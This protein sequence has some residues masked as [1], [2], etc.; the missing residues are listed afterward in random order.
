[1]NTRQMKDTLQ[2]QFEQHLPYQD[3]CISEEVQ[4]LIDGMFTYSVIGFESF[5][6]TELS[7]AISSGIYPQQLEEQVNTYTEQVNKLWEEW[8]E[9]EDIL[10]LVNGL[11]ED[12]YID[13]T[14][15]VNLSNNTIKAVVALDHMVVLFDEP[16][17]FDNFADQCKRAIE[18]L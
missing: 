17:N 2:E 1:M 15:Q 18:A 12:K 11:L 3:A 10:S 16:I 14:V 5:A 13:F 7:T 9:S 8:D 4:D 6:F